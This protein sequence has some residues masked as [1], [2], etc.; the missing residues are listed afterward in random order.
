[1]DFKTTY[2]EDKE[3]DFGKKET[4]TEGKKGTEK[5]TQTYSFNAETG[6]V[7]DNEPKVEKTEAVNEVIVVGTKPVI[8]TK[9]LDFKTTYV[10]DKEMD[11]GKKETRTEGKKG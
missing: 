3:M 1:M 11:F 7:T 9:D 2:V 5:T 4:R 10:E 6:D 8:T